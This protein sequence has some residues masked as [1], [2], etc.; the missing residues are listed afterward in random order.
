MNFTPDKAIYLQ[1]ADRICDQ[2]LA[3]EYAEE[4]RI[5]SVREYAVMLEVNVNTTVKAFDQLARDEVIY[6]KRGLGY[7]VMPGAA[8]RIR[9]KRRTQFIDEQLPSLFRSM[10]MLGIDIEEIDDAWAK[11][12]AKE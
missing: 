1:I 3:G 7:F 11:A 6:I 5:P 4:A 10:Q 2:I 8:R 9:Q 12:N